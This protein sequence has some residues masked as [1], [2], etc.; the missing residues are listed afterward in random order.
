MMSSSPRRRSVVID[1]LDAA[2]EEDGGEGHGA[3]RLQA[4]GGSHM[5]V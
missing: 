5:T 2:H 3:P 4:V 1:G